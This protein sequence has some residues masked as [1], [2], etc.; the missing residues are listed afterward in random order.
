MENL[1]KPAVQEQAMKNVVG[2][3]GRGVS[4]KD[5]AMADLMKFKMA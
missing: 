2:Q 1:Q 5:Q 3:M 4:D